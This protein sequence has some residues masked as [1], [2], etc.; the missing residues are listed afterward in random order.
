MLLKKLFKREKKP[1]KHHIEF[2]IS[3]SAYGDPD[4]FDKLLERDDVEVEEVGCNSHC[5]VCERSPYVLI[6]SERITASTPAE[7]YE[8]IEEYIKDFQ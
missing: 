5:E 3:N 4:V 7:L 1:F 8:K 6:N 2:C